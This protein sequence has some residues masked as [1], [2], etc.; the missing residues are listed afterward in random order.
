MKTVIAVLASLLSGG[1]V[2]A[3]SSIEYKT[4]SDAAKTQIA[5]HKCAD[6]EA[7][8]ADRALDIAHK[9]LLS[10]QK[11]DPAAA[12]KMRALEAAWTVYRDAFIEAM[13]PA[14][15]KQAA[16]GTMFAVEAL[17]TRARLTRLHTAEMERRISK[18]P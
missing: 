1:L 8:R 4:C 12:K 18:I 15:D 9:R 11:G 6:E 2:I 17:L 10:I 14:T 3:Q 16:Y 5:L 13:Y 7:R